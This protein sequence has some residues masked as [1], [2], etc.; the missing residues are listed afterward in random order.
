VIENCILIILI[1]GFFNSFIYWKPQFPIPKQQPA[2]RHISPFPFYWDVNKE[3]KEI[4]PGGLNGLPQC[5][6]LDKQGNI[7]FHKRKYSSGDEDLLYEEIKIL[8]AK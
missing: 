8:A 4:L 7:A 1:P 6:V 2:S 3:F 5:F